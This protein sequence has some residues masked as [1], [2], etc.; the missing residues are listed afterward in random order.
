MIPAP[1]GNVGNFHA[2]ARTALSV[3]GVGLAPAVAFAILL[4]AQTVVA[5][6]VAAGA[7]LISGDVSLSRVRA[8]TS[9]REPS[10]SA[11]GGAAS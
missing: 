1:P 8:A 11:G 3:L 9:A 5:L 4:H 6:V 7:F 2:F 10:G